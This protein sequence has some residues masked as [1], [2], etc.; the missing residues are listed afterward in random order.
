MTLIDD[1]I[2][3]HAPKARV[4]NVQLAEMV[5]RFRVIE[6]YSE[7]TRM[8]RLAREFAAK[9]CGPLQKGSVRPVPPEWLPF[10]PAE[11]EAAS[12]VWT[13]HSCCLGAFKPDKALPPDQEPAEGALQAMSQLDFLKLQAK[14]PF[15]F[16]YVREEFTRNQMVE[17]A[18]AEADRMDELKN[19][20][21]ETP[22]ESDV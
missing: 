13:L 5:L 8:Q 20:S 3:Q 4:F 14:L 2:E 19:D 11:V 18:N 15:L 21:G 17:S 10:L 9:L 6:D 7:W 1:L 22:S 16:A 12:L